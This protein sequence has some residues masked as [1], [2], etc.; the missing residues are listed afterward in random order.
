MAVATK[1]NPIRARVRE[2]M[3]AELGQH[4]EELSIELGR[5]QAALPDERRAV[6]ADWLERA[7]ELSKD[8]RPKLEHITN[9]LAE[10]ASLEK[11]SAEEHYR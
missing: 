6:L 10:P 11:L 5:M 9:E 3:A 2:Q 1:E 7:V 4:P 8:I